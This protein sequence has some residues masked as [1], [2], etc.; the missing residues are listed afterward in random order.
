MIRIFDQKVDI[1]HFPD[2]TQRLNIITDPSQLMDGHLVGYYDGHYDIYW[3]YEKE[4]EC[5]TL[6][7]V[8][9]HLRNA[10]PEKALDLTMYYIPNARMDRVKEK[11]EVFTLKYF[12]EFINSLGF[13]SVTVL[14][15]HSDV[16]AALFNHV[17]IEKY[18]GISRV[19][20]LVM[21]SDQIDSFEKIFVFFP[22]AGAAKR[23]SGDVDKA[24]ETLRK[25]M[26]IG[27]DAPVKI[28]YGKKNRDWATGKILGMNLFMQG[29]DEH[30][31]MAL[32]PYTAGNILEGRTVIM[33]DDIIAYGGTFYHGAKLLRQFGNCKLYASVTHTE[34]SV[35]DP[36]KGTFIKL[37]EDGTVNR[38]YTTNSLFTGQHEKITVFP[39]Y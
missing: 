23:Y 25:T 30:G 37:L 20:K 24:R 8:V 13:N 16:A 31:D 35:L 11:C 17:K 22:D 28:L 7:Y 4:E 38:L 10:F 39:V 26:D 32:D 36:E 15:P 3:Q 1:Q 14:D 33:A 21:V 27:D 9:K 2:G 34:N 5:M 12:S 6:Y 18:D 29:I 19:M